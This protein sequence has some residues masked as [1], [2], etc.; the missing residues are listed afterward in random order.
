MRLMWADDPDNRPDFG[1][2]NTA[3]QVLTESENEDTGYS[4]TMNDSGEKGSAPPEGYEVPVSTS[5]GNIDRQ[6]SSDSGPYADKPAYY[7]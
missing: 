3:I 4:Y 6:L 7:N 1:E 2:L 5:D